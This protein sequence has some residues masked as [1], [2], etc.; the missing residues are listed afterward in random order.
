MKNDA[1]ERPVR[2]RLTTVLIADDHELV[3]DGIKML[4]ASMWGD[5]RFVEADDGASLLRAAVLHPIVHLAFVDLNMPGMRDGLLLV[6][7]ARRHPNIPLVVISAFTSPDLVRRTMEVAAVHAF[8]P[9]SASVDGL[10]MAID[11]AMQGRKLGFLQADRGAP[12]NT[13]RGLTPRQEQIRGLLRQGMS[14]KL[15]AS[16]LGISEGTVKNH[17]SEIFR[18][19]NATN[20]TQ[21]AQINFGV[22]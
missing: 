8:V 10:R 16:T 21:A 22:E 11:A 6:E 9:K 17:L 7:L 19:L 14:N 5:V 4:V 15:I 3:R 18:T 12:N 2:G 20:R 13:S 1:D